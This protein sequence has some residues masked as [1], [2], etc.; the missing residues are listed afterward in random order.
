MDIQK[1]DTAV[2]FIDPQNDVLSEKGANWGAVGASVTENRTVDNM[3]RI[4]EAAKRSGYD[5]FRV[6]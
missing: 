2:V 5:E 4:F 6:E 3:E 1:T